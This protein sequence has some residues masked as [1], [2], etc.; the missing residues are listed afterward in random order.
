[1]CC[2]SDDAGISAIGILQL[3]AAL[4]F[5]AKFTT[6]TPIYYPFDL[7]FAIIFSVK[8]VFFALLLKENTSERRLS[9]FRSQFWGNVCIGIAALTY[10]II[11][12]IEWSVFPL[13][14]FVT[15]A[16]LG[17]IMVYHTVCIKRYSD[18]VDDKIS[19]NF[20]DGGQ[21]S[22]ASVIQ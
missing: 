21:T 19:A 17:A 13:F 18:L 10:L 16:F 8:V 2:C 15:W 20:I 14:I 4:F 7:V 6:F 11:Q 1:M 3:N 5:W 9:Y 12:W 22:E